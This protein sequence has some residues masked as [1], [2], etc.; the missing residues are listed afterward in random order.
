MPARVGSFELH[1]FNSS[2]MLHYFLTYF[3]TKL[4]FI[5]KLI[6]FLYN[7]IHDEM[8]VTIVPMVAYQY[9][10]QNIL[11]TLTFYINKVCL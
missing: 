10:F 9:I 2:N 11:K 1:Y 5:T 4:Y 3:A 6:F 7:R 8:C